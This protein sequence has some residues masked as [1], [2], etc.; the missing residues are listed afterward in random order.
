MTRRTTYPAVLA[1]IALAAAPLAAADA[2]GEAHAAQGLP[3]LD[4]TLRDDAVAGL[5]GVIPA[6]PMTC[7]LYTSDA[8]DEL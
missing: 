6:G 1:C 8:A 4:L 5:P 3:V 2:P 7:L